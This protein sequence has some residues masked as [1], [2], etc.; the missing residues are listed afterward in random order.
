MT[1]IAQISVICQRKICV[2]CEICGQILLP[3]WFFNLH[4]NRPLVN[5][6]ENDLQ[7]RST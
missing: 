3:I 5:C 6:P 7:N 2:I 4:I 1:Q